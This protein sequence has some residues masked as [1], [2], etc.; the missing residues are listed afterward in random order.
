MKKILAIGYYDDYARFFLHIE[1]ELK[2]V[3]TNLVFFYVNIYLSGF[4]YTLFNK[5]RITTL[6][7]YKAWFNVFL[8][9]KKYL[10]CI[11]YIDYKG[12]NLNEITKFDRKLNN[13]DDDEINS[14]KLQ[15]CAYI[16]IVIDIFESYKP[17]LLLLSDD[18]RLV[19]EIMNHFAK[20]YKV[21]VLYF[22]QGPFKTTIFDN[23]GVNANASIRDVKLDDSELNFSEKLEKINNFF[24]R[25]KSKNY[26]RIPFYRGVD[27]IVQL[28]LSNTSFFPID[29]KNGKIKVVDKDFYS[30]V[31]DKKINL[32]II[33]KNEKSNILLVLQ[34]PFD[35][36]LVYHSPIFKN[37]YEIVKN[38]H[39]AMPSNCNLI[40]REHPLY[41]S[42]YER[43]LYEII[44]NEPNVFIDVESK[45]NEMILKSTIV[46][47]NNSTVGIESIAKFKNTIVLGN[48]YYDKKE[49][50]F[51]LNS[52]EDLKSTILDAFSSKLNKNIIVDYLYKLCFDFLL[53]GH[54]RDDDLKNLSNDIVFKIINNLN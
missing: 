44:L 12:V 14:L 5:F 34:V 49:I 45:L 4:L 15:A 13:Y 16:D 52:K 29:L 50:C 26:R 19:I 10:E 11:N 2:L 53:E 6:I 9:K 18:S 46:I 38:V 47:V 24:D 43:E 30:L 33:E 37:H 51:K 32:K 54:Y 22:E 42:R 28:I 40:I 8:N 35:V 48:S 39:E 1:K 17:D 3:R 23:K 21:N 7:S 41:K 36:N 20:F 31:L 27:Y 25:P